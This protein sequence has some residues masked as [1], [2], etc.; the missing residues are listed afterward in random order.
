MLG[1]VERVG[2]LVGRQQPSLDAQTGVTGRKLAGY[3]SRFRSRRS[4]VLYFFNV[5]GFRIGGFCI[6][7]LHRFGGRLGDF[8]LCSFR[9]SLRRCSRAPLEHKR[10]IEKAEVLL[11]PL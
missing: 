7:F 6:S 10:P 5:G 11:A 1:V 4:L 3:R 2:R 9:R 8:F